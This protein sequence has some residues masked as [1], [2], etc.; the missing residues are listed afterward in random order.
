M[1]VEY[2]KQTINAKNFFARFAHRKRL[3]ISTKIID[4][5][6][7]TGNSSLLDFG[8][9]DGIFLDEISKRHANINLIGF[10]PYS[11]LKHST[12]KLY[13][14]LDNLNCESLDVICCFETIEHLYKDERDNLYNLAIKTLKKNCKF[15]ISVPIIGG[16]TLILKEINRAMIFKRKSDYSMKELFLA[17]FLNKEIKRA[18]NIKTSHKGFNYKKLEKELIGRFLVEKKIYSPFKNVPWFLNSNIFY[19]LKSKKL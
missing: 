11:N 4:N 9:G 3:K 8:C 10:D 14:N 17:S 16:L 12:F 18:E 1:N 2:D 6:N 13:D 15:I 7:L 19:I 5:L